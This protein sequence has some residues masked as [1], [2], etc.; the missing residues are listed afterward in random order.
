MLPHHGG[1]CHAEGWVVAAQLHKSAVI[2]EDLRVTVLV[3]PVYGVDA[4][5]RLVAVVYTL[6][7]AQHLLAG[8][9]ERNTLRG[10]D[11]CLAEKVEADKL[12]CRDARDA[13][14]K[15]VDNTHVVVAAD[16]GYHLCG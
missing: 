10:E 11:H 13:C 12:I 2:V 9:D 16:I 1:I 4:V 3:G 14:L 8:I 5:G 15:T 7:V 6:L